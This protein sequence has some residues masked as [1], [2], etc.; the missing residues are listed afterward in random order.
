MKPGAHPFLSPADRRAAAARVEALMGAGAGLAQARAPTFAAPTP[1]APVA[2]SDRARARNL[3]RMAAW[4]EATRAA[5][6]AGPDPCA[7]LMEWCDWL[8]RRMSDLGGGDCGRHLRGLTAFDLG[9]AQIALL[10]P[11]ACAAATGG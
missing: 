5:A 10:R 11:A 3:D 9:E 4:V 1:A 2:V 6:L 7:V 8:G